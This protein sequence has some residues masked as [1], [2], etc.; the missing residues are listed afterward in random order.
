MHRAFKNAKLLVA[1]S[2]LTFTHENRVPFT[3]G[4]HFRSQTFG[5]YKEKC[6]NLNLEVLLMALYYTELNC[7]KKGAISSWQVFWSVLH[8]GTSGMLW[9]NNSWKDL[10]LKVTWLQLPKTLGFCTFLPA[11]LCRRT[12]STN[13][14]LLFLQLHSI[15]YRMSSHC[16][17]K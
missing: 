11:Q 13:T 7:S 8:L 2:K 10:L 6:H 17:L 9:D 12:L 15:I 5:F 1:N 4:Y 3:D 16:I 14:C